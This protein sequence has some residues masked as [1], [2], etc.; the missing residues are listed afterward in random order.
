MLQKTSPKFHEK[1]PKETEKRTKRERQRET[2]RVK[3]LAVRAEGGLGSG[4]VW[5]GG[6]NPEK[7]EGARS[8]CHEFAEDGL[9]SRLP[10]DG[11]Q[12]I[13]GAT[14]QG[15][16]RAVAVVFLLG[17][18]RAVACCEVQEAPGFN[19]D[20]NKGRVHEARIKV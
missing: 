12:V 4:G 19:G 14:S 13:R 2:K 10:Q 6:P 5:F 16:A 15:S 7:S 8:A 11:T 17:G 1:T 3:N 18:T 9:P 20:G